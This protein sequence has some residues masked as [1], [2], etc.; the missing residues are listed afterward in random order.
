MI[1][2][3]KNGPAC[4]VSV[5]LLALGLLFYACS[6]DD[7]GNENPQ[8]TNKTTGFVV[9]VRN[10][11][12]DDLVKYFE[13]IPTDTI[14]I[15]DGQDFPTFF[16]TSLVGHAMFMNRPDGAGGFSKFVV[17][18]NGEVVE[19]GFMTT[20]EQGGN[21]GR[22]EA[23]DTEFGVFQDRQLP[24][25]INVFN[26][27]TL[28]TMATID[29]SP[30]FVPDDIGQSYQRFFFRDD[31]V[32]ATVRGLGG[33]AF[34]SLILHQANLASN[35]YVGETQRAGNGRGVIFANNGFGQNFTDESGNFYMA[36]AGDVTGGGIFA[37]INKI[38]AGSN[39][40]DPDYIFEPTRIINPEN[41]FLPTFGVFKYLGNDKAIAKV[42][43]E[44]PQQVIDIIDAAGGA[45]NLSDAEISQI[46]GIIIG[47]E[48][49]RYCVL[50]LNALTVT[51]IPDV[52]PLGI[53]FTGGAPFF[54]D[55][56]IYFGV[57]RN[58]G[59]ANENAYYKYN[60]ITGEAQKAFD[61]LGGELR[62]IYNI[63]N[64]N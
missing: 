20:L 22:I 29:M 32:F 53:L 43:V 2:P 18:S 49:S 34:P 58:S 41:T 27:T 31:D 15:S 1:L 12:G 55:G 30:G 59:A 4:L 36:D 24:D 16:P 5:A 54:H 44:T 23:R 38:P 64:D 21:A 7:E 35:N 14:D 10:S 61:I 60:H 46:Q 57:V 13:E 26:P 45:T 37:R 48:T 25:Q 6:S 56:E 3:I 63:A 39:D 51:P 40:I 47:S 50:D 8:L 33:Q 42:N 52:P 11:S 28:Q 62:G 19:E 17:N 9:V